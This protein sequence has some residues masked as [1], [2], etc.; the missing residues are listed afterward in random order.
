LYLTRD[1]PSLIKRGGFQIEQIE[2]GY[3]AQFPR[4]SSYSWWG[5]A[6]PD[7]IT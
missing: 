5:A 7:H 4:S 1:I 6:T 3:L 2:A